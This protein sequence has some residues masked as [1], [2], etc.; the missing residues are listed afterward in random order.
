MSLVCP[1]K[2]C[3]SQDGPCRC[4]KIISVLTL[5]VIVGL[6]YRLISAP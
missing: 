2:K 1:L 6:Y 5:L 3:K 4:E